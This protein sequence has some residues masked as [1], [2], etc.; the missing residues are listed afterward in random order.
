MV[1]HTNVR[2]HLWTLG[3]KPWITHDLKKQKNNNNQ[4]HFQEPN[5]LLTV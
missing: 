5:H 4:E 2:S 3:E 1:S